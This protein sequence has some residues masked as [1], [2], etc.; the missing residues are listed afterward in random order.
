VGGRWLILGS[1][2]H[3]R[4]LASVIR[5]RGE[6]VAALS[7]RAETPDPFLSGGQPAPRLFATDAEAL[8]H[9]AAEGLMVCVGVGGL[10]L[11][12]RICA[13]LVGRE[14]LLGLMRPLVAP[15]ATVDPSAALGPL[16]Q[17]L[18]HA[19]VGPLA[20]VGQGSIVNTGA[21]VEHDAVLG[22]IS[23]A[24]PG[25]VL[26]GGAQVGNRVLI[27]SGARVLPLVSVADG[28]V[29][30]AG[31]VVTADLLEASTVGGVPAKPLN[32]RKEVSSEQ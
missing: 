7:T 23:H 26:L 4:S 30:G 27:G 19:H 9:A 5:G 11:R 1:G 22:E 6:A 15:T 8:D 20:Q 21:I 17:V 14:D 29:V 12:A 16:S 28:T 10:E 3:A 25:A 18:E 32:T 31:A 2:G 24:A 13:G